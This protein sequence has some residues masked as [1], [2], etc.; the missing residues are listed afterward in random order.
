[1]PEQLPRNPPLFPTET[2]QR[3]AYDRCLD[4]ESRASDSASRLSPLVCARILGY[5][6]IHAP[7]KTGRVWIS[8]QIMKCGDDEALERLGEFFCDHFIRVC[9]YLS[10]SRL[11]I[12]PLTSRTRSQNCKS[13]HPYALA[14]LF[15]LEFRARSANPQGCASSHSQRSEN[16]KGPSQYATLRHP[17]LFPYYCF[18]ALFRDNYCCL[19]TGYCDMNTCENYPE[20]AARAD[21]LGTLATPTNAAYIFPASTNKW[22]TMADGGNTK[23]C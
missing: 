7:V 17:V 20:I 21:S 6:I 14:S 2:I 3:K 9:E 4:F 22:I 5:M 10:K 8:E 19:I 1:M 16:S 18:Q 12:V 23:V 11:Y 13:S 15:R